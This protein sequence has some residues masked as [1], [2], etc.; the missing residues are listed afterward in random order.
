ML[1]KSFGI[2]NEY[3]SFRAVKASA[4]KDLG[5]AM[6]VLSILADLPTD[7]TSSEWINGRAGALYLHCTILTW[8]PQSSDMIN[9]AMKPMIEH[10]FDQEPWVWS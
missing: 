8:L 1:E 7:P 2:T 9:K 5:H 6:K 10:L 3:L 4:A